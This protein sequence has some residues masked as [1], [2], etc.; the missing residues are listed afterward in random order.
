MAAKGISLIVAALAVVCFDGVVEAQPGSRS[1]TVKRE[2]NRIR[3]TSVGQGFSIASMN[4][5][6]MNSAR[7]FTPNNPGTSTF[8][9]AAGSTRSAPARSQAASFGTTRGSA[10]PK[11]FSSVSR[12][13]V[14]SPY[15]NLF[16]N[17]FDGDFDNYNTL[18]R[19]QLQQQAINTQF[20]QQ[21]QMLSR[22]YQQLTA[23]PSFNPQ[24]SQSQM[25]TG[26][27]TT[28]NNLSRYYPMAQP[29]R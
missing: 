3:N 25:P 28:F 26:H 6:S 5:L 29:R 18:V 1:P 24:G 11:P 14:V 15:L 2:L 4:A 7:T 19:P 13:P 21:Q 9:Q 23:R 16:R 20:Q 8:A 17:G 22:Q 10:A 27:T 12:D